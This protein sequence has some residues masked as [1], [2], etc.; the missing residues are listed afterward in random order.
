[1]GAKM[2]KKDAWLNL[3][4]WWM[5]ARDKFWIK[6]GRCRKVLCWPP[7]VLFWPMRFAAALPQV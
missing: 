7:F 3:G 6:L 2:A 5:R 4:K 1:M